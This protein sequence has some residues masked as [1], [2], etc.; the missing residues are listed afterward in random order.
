[1]RIDDCLATGQQ[2]NQQ[3]ARNVVGQIADQPHTPG[4]GQCREI[5]RQGIGLVN[6]QPC[7]RPGLAQASN[8][9]AVDLDRIEVA[10]PI[11]QFDRECAKPGTDLDETI[12]IAR[13]DRVADATE[14]RSVGQEMLA[15]SL[16]RRMLHWSSRRYST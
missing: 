12:I 15:E 6:R 3:R 5:K 11:E 9:I 1:M 7:L 16:A 8:Q 4:T 13:V 2:A 10:D 14:D